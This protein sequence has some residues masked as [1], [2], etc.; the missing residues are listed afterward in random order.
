MEKK[1]K[2][3]KG[4]AG[5]YYISTEDGDIETVYECK[6]KGLF[7]KEK[8]KPLVGDNVVIDI[9]DEKKKLGNVQKILPRQNKL[10]RPE[11]ANVDQ[12]LIIFAL[13]NPEPNFNLLDRLLIWMQKENVPTIICFNKVDLVD[14]KRPE[15]IKKIYDEKI[16]NTIFTSTKKDIGIE[17][18]RDIL[19]GKTTVIAGPSGVGKSSIINKIFSKKI[20]QTGAISE[21]IGRGKHTTRHS[22]MFYVDHETYIFD[23]PGFSS[24]KVPEMD[25]EEL[26]DYYDEFQPFANNCRFLGCTHTHEPDCEIKKKVDTGEISSVRYDNYVQ[27]YEEIKEWE[28]RR[29]K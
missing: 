4:I 1:G 26:V 13:N 19:S 8:I 21:K 28:K 9:A 12:A 16:F 2:I 7:R 3:I 14:A 20:S 24:L 6:A 18:I 5:F 25:K 10:I 29:Y 11:V 17:E 27:M 22:E 15:E 23:T